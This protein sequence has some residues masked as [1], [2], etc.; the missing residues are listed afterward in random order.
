MSALVEQIS[1]V[2]RAH[3]PDKWIHN[4]G[5]PEQCCALP[6]QWIGP[7]HAAHVAEQIESELQP[8]HDRQLA[9]AWNAGFK[10]GM[11]VRI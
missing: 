5:A 4:G 10:E 3:R 2:L 1:E 9:Q 11:K 7:D 6:C 8:E